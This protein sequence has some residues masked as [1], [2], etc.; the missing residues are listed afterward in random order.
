L[1]AAFRTLGHVVVRFRWLIV[2]AWLGAVMVT[3]AFLPSLGSEVNNNNSQF[4]P[5]N[6]ASNLASDLGV[7]VLGDQTH[8]SPVLIV[9]TR[10]D[11]RL[12]GADLTA[13]DRDLA[14]LRAI[15]KVIRARVVG[16][17]A[18]DR[19][20]E[21][22][23][24]ATITETNI[25]G[26][27]R[28]IDR[29]EAS[30]KG[31]GAPSGLALHVAG[32]VATNVANQMK[33]SS[34][35]NAVQLFS[36]L[37][38]IVLL[39]VIFRSLLAPVIT[40]VPA[41]V[42]LLVASRLIGAL[43]QHGLS[44]SEITELLLIVLMLGAGTDYGL[45]LVFR[46]REE[47]R[48]SRDPHEA[49][50]HSLA[51]VGESITASAATVIFALLSLL[52]ASFGIYRDLG[53]PLAIGIAVILLSGLTLLPALLAITGK[54]AFWPASIAPGDHR[55]EWRVRAAARVLSRP[56]LALLIGVAAF[57]GLASFAFSFRAGG[58]SGAVDAPAGSDAAIGNALLTS[59]FPVASADPTNLVFRF[60]SPVY[61]DPA[62]LERGAVHLDESG[63]F[64]RVLDALDATGVTLTPA[65]YGT[66][67][68]ELGDPAALPAVQPPG[69]RQ[70]PTTIYNAFRSTAL[71]ISS[72][73]R[74]VQ[75]EVGL[76]AGPASSTAAVDAIPE[77]RRITS[78]TAALMGARQS[79]VAGEAPSLYDVA[80]TSNS[81]LIHI[82][83]IAV[84]A[85]GLLLALVLRSLV[86]P[87]YLI[88]SVALSYLAA[89]GV[90]V[91]I[92]ID[93]GGSGGITFILPFLM[94]IFLL[95]LGED[96]NILVMTRIREEAHDLPL[97]EA[98]IQALGRTGST[99][100]SAGLVLAGTF[101]VLAVA[102]RSG[103][104][105]NQ[106]VAIG[107]GLAI[108]VLMDTFVV[109]TVLVPAT[110]I[111]LGRA[112]WWPSRLGRH[113][114]DDTALETHLR[115]AS[116]ELSSPVT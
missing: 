49:V 54:A 103:P 1:N 60:S 100:T 7:P 66:L 71:F 112:N 70:W 24:N 72:D 4:L 51:R 14:A 32:P 42:A 56:A 76:V 25:V 95:A 6:A 115:R 111:L 20:A 64:T 52:L 40:L 87:L 63:A 110:V 75:F 85:I 81:D 114:L 79:G 67:R 58:F 37:F 107:I 22:L 113:Q 34:T 53:I 55:D 15:P 19:A 11:G 13:V 3:S 41:A 30:F 94:F 106:V 26:E 78:A 18:D 59:D 61:M 12:S 93:I 31:I 2:I 46:V 16:L 23:L 36:I 21:I 108:G 38:I 98:V 96:Y 77:V 97:R 44:I 27:T 50:A 82:V 33:S 88:V 90:S 10:S 89:L 29:I 57:G 43:G 73:G 28:L 109:R 105:G 68:R 92:F 9:A 99:I 91:L 74:T 39:L 104:G 48:E 102:A 83:P 65:E 62:V 5:T 17:S 86:A 84:L 35:G 69:L 80:S 101:A 8:H 45:F 116:D 47:L